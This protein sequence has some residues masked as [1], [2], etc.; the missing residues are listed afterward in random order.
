MTH[1]SCSFTRKII[2][3]GHTIRTSTTLSFRIVPIP[4]YGCH[5]FSMV[6][7]ATKSAQMIL[8]NSGGSGS[9][10]PILLIIQINSLINS[11]II[12]QPPFK[13]IFSEIKPIL[14][15]HRLMMQ[16]RRSGT[17]VTQSVT[18]NQTKL[19]TIINRMAPTRASIPKST[20]KPCTQS[21]RHL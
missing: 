13:Q 14:K 6:S 7:Q 10:S 19:K 12:I 11:K 21:T 5:F 2:R 8:L 17:V 15:S 16:S 3:T 18:S 4:R 20:S 1:E 9:D